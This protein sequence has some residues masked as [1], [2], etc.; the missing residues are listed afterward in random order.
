[1]QCTHIRKCIWG[2]IKKAAIYKTERKDPTE[3]NSNGIMNSDF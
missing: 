1:M 3:T 2:H